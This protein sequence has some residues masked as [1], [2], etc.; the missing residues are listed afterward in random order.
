MKP[1]MLPYDESEPEVA[2]ALRGGWELKPSAN[3]ACV[4]PVRV[5]PAL[6]GGWELKRNRSD[7]R[8]AIGV[9]CTRPS[10]RVGIETKGH[11]EECGYIIPGCT[12]PSGRVGIET[13]FQHPARRSLDDRVAPALR[14]GWELKLGQDTSQCHKASCTRP[15]GRVGIETAWDCGA[16]TALRGRCTRP[17]GRVGMGTLNA[18]CPVC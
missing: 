2:P 15:S 10:G 6:R 14:G 13:F 12:R 3:R 9:G 8:R 16:R 11:A 5:A 7:L 4:L 17:S 1:E 18:Y